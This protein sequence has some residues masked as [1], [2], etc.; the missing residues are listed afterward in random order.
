MRRG[1]FSLAI[2]GV[3]IASGA[4]YALWQIPLPPGEPPLLE[5]TFMCAS[6]VTTDCTRDN[7]IA[8][9]TGGVDRD[10]VVYEQIPPV[11]LLALL[12]T[13]DRQFFEHAGVDPL[14]VARAL[15]SEVNDDDLRQG[16]S[17]ITQ[18]YVKNAYLSAER[19]WSRKVREAI[20]AIKLEREL[21]KQEILQRY[22][23]T[24]YW[25]RGAYGIQAAART[26]FDLD[27]EELGLAESAYLAGIIRAPEAADA[28]RGPDDPLFDQQRSN[29]TIR[30]ATVLQSMTD[31][32]WITPEQRDEVADRNWDYVK[33]RETQTNYGRVARP[34]IG[35][36]YFVDYT[37]R[38]LV[39][40]GLFTDAEVYGGGLRIYTTVD[41]FDQEAAADAVRSTLG[42][43]D[44]PQASLVALNDLGGVQAMIGG[45]DFDE[46]QVNLATGTLGGGSGRQ[47]GSSY[48][49]IVLATAL[50]EGV[51]LSQTYSSPGRMTLSGDGLSEDWNVANYADAGQGT[52]N[53]IDATRLSSNTAYAQLILD[54]GVS[55][56][57]EM[58]K[59]LGISSDVPEVPAIALGAADVSVLDMT[60][61]F[62]VFAQRGERV[63]PWPVNRVT[64]SKGRVL[65]EAPR[66]RMRV[67]DTDVAD[68]VNY[69]LRQVVETGTGTS[70]RIGQVA[71]GKTGTAENFRDAW[72]VGYTCR[73]TAGVWVGYAG[74]ET[75]FMD[76]VRGIEVVGG[77]YPAQIWAKF[78][79]RATQGLEDCDFQRPGTPPSTFV[80]P[81]PQVP[82]TVAPEVVTTTIPEEPTTTTSQ[83]PVPEPTTVPTLP[84]PPPPPP[85]PPT[86]VA[87][88]PSTTLPPDPGR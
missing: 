66:N 26:Y 52:L 14:A 30:R 27:V 8:Q 5:T 86:T 64:D 13:E 11:F 6:D 20:L 7:S 21:P 32:G 28:N 87:P 54:V 38:W 35:T 83:A 72:F 34:E 12:A 63:G 78:M 42:G 49:A 68:E 76:N 82:V 73:L 33:V 47:P 50:Q 19:T 57:V 43:P 48:K 88:Q 58:S 25:G 69:V 60:T 3:L 44:D 71:A 40:N 39:D 1:I 74:N 10:T 18:Q 22:L 53:L 2:A 31:L 77:S 23:N 9:L 61:A 51:P 81:V 55:D 79:N 45:F 67:L 75:R 41:M 37:R 15:V 16:G 24:I 59:R 65:W 56:V 80:S 36:E 17:T 29:A 70:A 4:V 84:P 46:S 85:P 62:S